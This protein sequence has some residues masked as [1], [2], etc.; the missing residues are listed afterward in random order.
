MLHWPFSLWFSVK[1]DH[2]TSQTVSPRSSVSWAP[3][4]ARHC[5]VFLAVES[6]FFLWTISRFWAY[7]FIPPVLHY[8]S[9][10]SNMSLNTFHVVFQ[11]SLPEAYCSRCYFTFIGRDVSRVTILV[12]LIFNVIFI[13]WQDG[14]AGCRS[15]P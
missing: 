6:G 8:L 12:F 5:F 15:Q 9:P 11:L 13:G 3:K 1:H 4:T 2:L 7:L 14:S 10:V